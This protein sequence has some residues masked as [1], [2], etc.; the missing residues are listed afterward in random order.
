MKYLSLS[1]ISTISCYG[2][3][4]ELDLYSLSIFDHLTVAI[5]IASLTS[6]LFLSLAL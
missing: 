3:V 2:I 6:Y 5:Y 1:L 4:K